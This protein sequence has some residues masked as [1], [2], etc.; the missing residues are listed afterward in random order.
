MWVEQKEG[1][2]FV[3]FEIGS[4][5]NSAPF[6]DILIAR[7]MEQRKE[8]SLDY[9]ERK[10]PRQGRLIVEAG[11]RGKI[12]VK[13][14]KGDT[15]IHVD[16]NLPSNFDYGEDLE[17][18]PH[19]GGRIVRFGGETGDLVL[20]LQDKVDRFLSVAPDPRDLVGIA[21]DGAEM[22]RPGGKAVFV[23]EKRPEFEYLREQALLELEDLFASDPDFSVRRFDDLTDEEI[24]RILGVRVR[25][26]SEFP[27]EKS[28]TIV[29]KKKTVNVV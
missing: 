15:V 18:K 11:S 28:L 29:I 13:A 27:L 16:P 9:K 6:R 8:T 1:I 14:R 21:Q 19:S 26:N 17:N 5:H 3:S 10:S 4:R 2:P 22:I 20:R 24:G 23:L 12:S 25:L 7:D